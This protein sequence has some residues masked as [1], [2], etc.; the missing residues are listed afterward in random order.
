MAGTA[1]MCKMKRFRNC[2]DAWAHSYSH[3]FNY[4]LFQPSTIPWNMVRQWR[5]YQRMT[6]VENE[7]GVKAL[8]RTYSDLLWLIM[9]HSWQC[10][11]TVR[12]RWC[13]PVAWLWCVASPRQLWRLELGTKTSVHSESIRSPL[14][15]HSS[16]VKVTWLVDT[17]KTEPKSDDV[18]MG[19]CQ[20]LQLESTLAPA[21]FKSSGLRHEDDRKPGSWCFV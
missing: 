2:G 13:L 10:M 11:E 4:S 16:I 15:V 17:P 5:V 20:E 8:I 3:E 7:T 1:R 9:V 21:N 6:L 14:R 19:Q 12:S 18:E